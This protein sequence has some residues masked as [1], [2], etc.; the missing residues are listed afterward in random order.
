MGAGFGAPFRAINR[1]QLREASTPPSGRSQESVWHEVYDTQT[2]TSAAT[3]TATF[4]SA[5]NADKTLSNMEASGQF[6]SPQTFRIHNICLDWITAIPVTTTAG[7]VLGALD[8]LTRLTLTSRATWT[9]TISSKAY[10]PYSLSALHGT[11]GPQGMG[12]G[13]FTAEESIQFGINTLTPGWNYFGRIIIPEQVSFN[14]VVNFAAAVTTTGTYLL[15]LSMFGV[16]ARRV[17]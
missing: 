13:T 9:L 4:F 12:Y 6:P 5:T 17:V 11:G 16:L 10:G 15:R 3:V 8:D 7:G 2:F 14:I 1:A